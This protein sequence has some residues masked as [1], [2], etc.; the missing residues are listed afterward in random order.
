MIEAM[1]NQRCFYHLV[2]DIEK[3]DKRNGFNTGRSHVTV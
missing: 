3:T 1:A 2:A